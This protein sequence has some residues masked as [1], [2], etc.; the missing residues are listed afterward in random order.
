[1]RILE[2]KPVGWLKRVLT[3]FLDNNCSMHAA[4]LTYFALLAVIPVLCCVL[5]AAK[6]CRVDEYARARRNER[7]DAMIVNIEKGQDDSLAAAAGTFESAAAREKKR[8]AAEEFGAQARTISNALFERVENFDVGT[9][10]WI[11]FGFLLWTVISSLASVETSFNE[12]FDVR[13]ARPVWKRA[14]MYLFIMIVL[15]VM[16]TVAMSLPVLNIA[17]NLIDATLGR[18][19]LTR[20]AGAGLIWFLDWGFFRYAVTLAFSSLFFGFFYLVIPNCRVR[21]A[22]ALGGGLV[23]AL[24]FSGWL[25]LCAVAQ[26]GIANSS[27]LYGSFAF[28]PIV[29]A[30]LYMSWQIVLFGACV[31]K[32]LPGD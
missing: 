27:A 19:W 31:V 10:G 12:I 29:L 5:V 20:W 11:G 24:L 14:Y 4:G 8:I 13:E 23:T 16:A 30:W 3:R 26:V 28:L 17:K 2:T 32:E 22:A 25:R 21:P 7:I 18:T 15:P 1:M 9:L 6:A